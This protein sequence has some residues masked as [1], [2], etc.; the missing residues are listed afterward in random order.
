MNAV[1]YLAVVVIWGTT[2]IA[3]AAQ[4]SVFSPAVGVFW[5]FTIAA[6]GLF[7]VLLLS[8]RLKKLSLQDHYFCML[9]GLCVF[10][11][12]FICFYTAVEYINSGL[13]S[14]IFSMAVLF[15]AINSYLFFKKKISKSF[16]PAA[17]CGLIGICALFWHDIVATQ[18]HWQTLSAIGLCMLGTYGFSLGNMISLRHQNHHKDI[19]TTNAYGML[20]GALFMG[21]VALLLKQNF[22][23]DLST[24]GVLAVLYLAIFGSIIGFSL[25]FMLIARIGAGRAAYSTLLFPLVALFIST[26]WEN[27][28]WHISSVLGVLFILLGNWIL[29]AQPKYFLK[30]SAKISSS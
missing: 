29:F 11:L 1:L 5:R 27:Y 15:N 16:I 12:N 17:I 13:E 18:L 2:W 30:H 23:P 3:I 14:V 26:F 28:H 6:L 20:Y 22:I 4:Q 8:K 7:V 21:I 9:Q 24:K 25:Y 10:G 19:F